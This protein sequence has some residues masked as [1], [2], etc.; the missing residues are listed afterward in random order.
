MTGR[1]RAPSSAAQDAQTFVEASK[2]MTR[3]GDLTAALSEVVVALGFDCVTMIHHVRPKT[4]NAKTVAYSDYPEGF[5]SEALRRHYFADDPVLLACERTAAPFLWSDLPKLLR[6]TPWQ[7]EILASAAECG[8]SQGLTIPIH[9]PGEPPAS[10]SFG[11]KHRRRAPEHAGQ[12]AAW[13]GAFAF[14]QARRIVGLGQGRADRPLLTP[15]QHDC[16]VLLGQGKSD[17]DIGALLGISRHTAHEHI[18][19][20]KRRYAVATRSQLLAASLADGQVTFADVL[21]YPFN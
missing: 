4:A 8:L 5:L 19:V 20:L 21:P 2:R 7:L 6:L 3:M 1:R 11:L 12:A 15:R 10:C 9:V 17:V 18:E 13:V 14:E 16:L